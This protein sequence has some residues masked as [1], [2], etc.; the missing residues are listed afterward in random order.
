MITA[1]RDNDAQPVRLDHA[2]LEARRGTKGRYWTCLRPDLVLV[3]DAA[4][5]NERP[6]G[7]IIPLEPDWSIRMVAA[8]RLRAVLQGQKPRE[9]F[10]IQRRKRIAQAL[11]TDDGRQSGAHFRDIAAVYFGA[12]RVGAESWKTS[13][14]KAYV[15]RLASNGRMLTK[16]GHKHLLRGKI[17][18]EHNLVQFSVSG[19]FWCMQGDIE[20]TDHHA[21]IIGRTRRLPSKPRSVFDQIFHSGG[22]YVLD[23]S[24]RTMAEWF[25][26]TFDLDIF[27]E[28]FQVEGHSKGKT[29]R[30]FV[31]VAEPRLV[32]R[33][34]RAL[35]LYR[36]EIPD[37]KESDPE[38][39]ARLKDW[40]DRFTNELETASTIKLEDALT[41]FSRDT[42]L[43]KLRASIAND[44][45]AEKP[46]VAL[47]RVHTYCVKRFR[48]LLSDRGQTVDAK[49]P[50]DAIFGAYGKLLR[51][52][53]DVTGFALPALR[54]QHRLFD[55]LNQ[56]RNKRSFAHDNDLLSVSEAQFL[57][58][59]VLASLAFIER[60]EAER[61]VSEDTIPF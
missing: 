35:W 53:G 20:T 47:D 23:F 52:A 34:L 54:V 12:A 40:L 41:D 50:L 45:I 59:S 2:I 61:A 27:Q 16:Q 33:V 25:E 22:G 15:A 29:L 57:I 5:S 42:T 7:I 4:L 1:T 30:G 8:Q 44:L 10:T 21:R 60:I 55:S 3:S 46:D 43:P 31:E 13:S 32:A 48:H 14:L 37:Y 17:K 56:A 38:E 58:D 11:R 24:D 36:C 49:T 9:W 19:M 26:E 39:E 51:D 28:R 6:F 18:L